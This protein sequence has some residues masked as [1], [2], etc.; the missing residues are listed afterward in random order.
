[1]TFLSFQ[2]LTLLFIYLF[3]PNSPSIEDPEEIPK[4][5]KVALLVQTPLI[6]LKM[7]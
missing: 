5:F 7:L 3:F 2:R 1:M 6:T 4:S